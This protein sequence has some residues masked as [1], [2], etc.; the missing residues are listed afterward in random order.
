[1]LNQNKVKDDKD[2]E[3]T[4]DENTIMNDSSKNNKRKSHS[5]DSVPSTVKVPKI[6]GKKD[7]KVNL[8]RELSFRK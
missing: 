1:M 7:V 8:I 6:N 2:D 4:I 5:D 3:N